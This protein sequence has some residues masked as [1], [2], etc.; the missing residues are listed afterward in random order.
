MRV[1]PSFPTELLRTSITGEPERR[2][3]VFDVFPCSLLFA[4]Q[5]IVPSSSLLNPCFSQFRQ[6]IE[7]M[8]MAIV[9]HCCIFLHSHVKLGTAAIRELLNDE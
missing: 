7:L 9:V 1:I 6:L 2:N 5:C 8:F 3:S 4:T